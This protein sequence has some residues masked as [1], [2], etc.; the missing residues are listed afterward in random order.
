MGTGDARWRWLLTRTACV[1]KTHVY[2]GRI[3]SVLVIKDSGLLQCLM[4]LVQLVDIAL[5]VGQCFV[6]GPQLVQLV[7]E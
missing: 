1:I 2:L 5:I 4:V 6:D 7:L 3:R